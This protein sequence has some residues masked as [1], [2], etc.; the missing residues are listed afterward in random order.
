MLKNGA[1]IVLLMVHLIF[2]ML[3]ILRIRVKYF[4]Y[5]RKAFCAKA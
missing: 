3:S 1:T 5:A 2:G 4:A